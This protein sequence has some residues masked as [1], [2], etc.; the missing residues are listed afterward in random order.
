MS[1]T[2]SRRSKD[3][4]SSGFFP[5]DVATY[6]SGTRGVPPPHIPELHLPVD[7][8]KFFASNERFGI[9]SIP[10]YSKNRVNSLF[11]TRTPVIFTENTKGDG[12]AFA[13]RKGKAKDPDQDVNLNLVANGQAAQPQQGDPFEYQ[14]ALANAGNEVPGF[15]RAVGGRIAGLFA[16]W[17]N[18]RAAQPVQAQAQA[19]PVQA[20]VQ[21]VQVQ[22]VQAQ[23]VQVQPVQV[24]PVQAQPVQV[25]PV[26]VQP[27]QAQAQ[28]QP[29][30]AQPVQVQP[31]AQPVQAQ[32]LNAYNDP[33]GND[34]KFEIV[35]D[36]KGPQRI[37][38]SNEDALLVGDTISSKLLNTPNN[39]LEAA[40][41]NE[42]ARYRHLTDRQREA[43]LATIPHTILRL[44]DN[45]NRP[46][47]RPP[48]R[49][50]ARPVLLNNPAVRVEEAPEY[51]QHLPANAYIPMPQ[52]IAQDAPRM[53]LPRM[54]DD[55]PVNLVLV[56][57]DEEKKVEVKVPEEES[58]SESSIEIEF[59]EDTEAPGPE[60]IPAKPRSLKTTTVNEWVGRARANLPNFASALAGNKK[61]GEQSKNHILR[62]VKQEIGEESYNHAVS[63]MRTY[64]YQQ[65]EL[66]KY[67]TPRGNVPA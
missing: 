39:R 8:E 59:E 19:Q 4:V 7:G 51:L 67:A 23:P 62:Q 53:D 10:F 64:K 22:P 60:Q 43:L 36:G 21:P 6:M 5:G 65:K 37:V 20:Q 63:V 57:N 38:L 28:A 47:A 15:F 27:V 40:I 13:H 2:F 14:D 9:A 33:F 24:Q 3:R 45:P 44:R 61:L 56:N 1:V 48:A 31:Q 35:E 18:R 54:D 29:V 34:A 32:P 41:R 11:P 52:M 58:G 46:P 66:E 30:Q 55:P 17:N 49:A 25:Q 50:H 16:R 12:L 26:Q 42:I